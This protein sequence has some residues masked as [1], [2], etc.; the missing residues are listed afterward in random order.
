MKINEIITEM[1]PMLQIEK[2]D[3]KETVLV[4][5]KSKVRTVVPKDPNK[6]GMIKTNDKGQL[7]LDTKTS[8]KI[9]RGIKP[10]DAVMVKQ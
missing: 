10:G 7:E 2:D 6:P 4:D 8:G 1:S 5:P 3:D 9:E